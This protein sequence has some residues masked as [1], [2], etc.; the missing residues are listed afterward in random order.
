MRITHP[1]SLCG[2]SSLRR[3]SVFFAFIITPKKK[4]MKAIYIPFM[5]ILFLS[6]LCIFI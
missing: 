3:G 2:G 6:D 4:P 1:W 5:G